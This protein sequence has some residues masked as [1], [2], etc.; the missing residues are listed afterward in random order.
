MDQPTPQR[1]RLLFSKQQAVKYIGHL[2][3]MLAWERALRRARI[4]LAYSKGFNPRPKMQA[5]SSLPLGTTGTAEI[6]DITLT[7]ATMPD[8]ILDRIQA[9]LPG[10]IVLHQIDEVPLKEPAL[11]ERVRQAIYAVVVETDLSIDRLNEAVQKLLTAEEIWQTRRRRK[12]TE[13]VNIKPWLH[14]LTLKSKTDGDAHFEM[15]LSCGQ[16]GNLR[17]EQV[18]NALEL[19]DSWYTIERTQLI[20]EGEC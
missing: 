11:Q 4:P 7:D 15:R 19:A 2:D 16:H 5:A 10:G 3:L 17:P 20:F 6:L 18:L 12:R 9:K 1:L 8:E 14:A 13:N